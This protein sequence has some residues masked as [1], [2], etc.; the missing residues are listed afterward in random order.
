MERW[1]W[2]MPTRNH[3]CAFTL[4]TLFSP[5][6]LSAGYHVLNFALNYAPNQ[7]TPLSNS[8]AIAPYKQCASWNSGP[9]AAGTSAALQLSL[10]VEGDCSVTVSPISDKTCSDPG[11]NTTTA[12]L[13]PWT[14]STNGVDASGNY[15]YT[16]NDLL[17]RGYYTT[18][19]AIRSLLPSDASGST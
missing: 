4:P 2:C 15:A 13:N 6:S 8:Y 7:C 18:P 17:L 19:K 16:Y 14:A 10:F 3:S 12:A 5:T 1:P 9:P 11:A